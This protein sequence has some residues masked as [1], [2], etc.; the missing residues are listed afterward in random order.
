MAPPAD[1]LWNS[2]P[3]TLLKHQVYRQYLRCWMGKICQRFPTSAIV[4]A[5]AGPGGYRDGP[6]GSPV[7]IA[8]TFLE[9][10]G[11]QRFNQLRLI[12]QEKRPD[13]RDELASRLG[14]LPKAHKLDVQVPPAG[15]LRDRFIALRS[16][17]HG[18]DQKTPV[19]WILDP[20][21][22]SSAPFGLVRACLAGPWDEV[23]IT[24]F[25]DEI[26]RFSGDSSKEQA[27]DRHF[28]TQAWR[29]SRQV[30]REGHRKEALLE[31]YQESLQSLP[32]VHT[33][34]F[35]IAGKNETAR[36]ALVFATHSDA[37]MECFNGTKW[38]MDPS[39]GHHVSEKRSLDQVDLFGDTP[40]TSNLRTWLETQARKALSFEELARH[41]GRLGFQEKHLRTELSNLAEDG[42]AV[43]EH[44]LEHTRTPWPAGCRVRFY[45]APGDAGRLPTAEGA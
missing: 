18:S 25:A 8:K 13:R 6:D 5:F 32:Q 15:E 41:A 39:H 2:E 23:L 30:F 3:R 37:G 29:Q 28:G 38:R 11:L 26:Y 10:S 19:L 27:I 14:G 42:L 21:D 34:A 44:P 7:V 33:G 35:S 4:D 1:M 12:C 16:A 40:F 45:A 36:Y 9:H 20:F 43:R 17:A 31:I 24:W 22:Y